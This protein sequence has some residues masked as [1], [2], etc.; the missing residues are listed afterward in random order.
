MVEQ[1]RLLNTET[2]TD[3][4]THDIIL[5]TISRLLVG[6]VAGLPKEVNLEQSPVL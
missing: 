5:S 2:Q 1:P 6:S 4:S 3:S